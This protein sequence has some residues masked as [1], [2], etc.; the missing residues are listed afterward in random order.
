VK[1]TIVVLTVATLTF[2]SFL[3]ADAFARG[4]GWGR[5]GGG[6]WGRSDRGDDWG[7]DYGGGSV[8]YSQPTD[9][10][11]A[12]PAAADYARTS[13]AAAR[14]ATSSFQPSAPAKRPGAWQQA[15]PNDAAAANRAQ[16]AQGMGGQTTAPAAASRRVCAGNY[17]N[18]GAATSL[19]TNAVTCAAKGNSYWY[20]GGTYYSRTANGYVICRPPVA[21]VVPALPIGSY[22]FAIAERN[23]WYYGGAYYCASGDSYE[24]TSPPT[25]AVIADLPPDA[26]QVTIGGQTYYDCDGTMYE[27]VMM[28]GETCYRVVD[29]SGN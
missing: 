20:A 16:F 26:K 27:A 8:R 10:G 5:G 23:Y 6:G 1:R 19:P 9:Y 14:P 3:A 25:G 24:V 22:P 13:S 11:W 28:N 7:G 18:Y 4:G 21:C 15:Q 12:Q 2:T 29:L 17:P